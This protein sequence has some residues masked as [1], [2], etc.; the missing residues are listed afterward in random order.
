[1]PLGRRETEARTG[2]STN[3]CDRI[4]PLKP[5]ISVQH[6]RGDEQVACSVNGRVGMEA[7]CVS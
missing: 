6:P 3:F 1:M 4:P 2:E 5:G 7:H